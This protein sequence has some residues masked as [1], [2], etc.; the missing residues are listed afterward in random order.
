M[1]NKDFEIKSSE[2]REL[3]NTP[4]SWMAKWGTVFMLLALVAIV[5]VSYALKYPEIIT[6]DV[7]ISTANPPVPVVAKTVGVLSEIYIEEGQSVL[8]GEEI[9]LSSN[10][11][12]YSDIIEL[13]HQLKTFNP[14][15]TTTY[16]IFYDYPKEGDESMILG[17]VQNEF[18]LL[19]NY[20]R[21]YRISSQNPEKGLNEVRVRE[22]I[23]SL[24]RSIIAEKK[25]LPTIRRSIEVH[26]KLVDSK[27]NEYG[28]KEITLSEFQEFISERDIMEL[29]E[30]KIKTNISEREL[31]IANLNRQLKALKT[32][33]NY[34]SQI[35]FAKITETYKNLKN[36]V[37]NWKR[38]NLITAPASGVIS[39]YDKKA[40]QNKYYKPDEEILAILS[41]QS[42]Q[43]EG[44]VE[45]PVRH[46]GRIQEGQQ[47][48]I[49][50]HSFP[51]QEFGK[52]E[53]TVKY[54]SKVPKKG[55]HFI[56][57]ELTNHLTTTFG[58]EI[59]EEQ[60]LVGVADIITSDKSL[61]QTVFQE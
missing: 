57:V 54:K 49:K 37:E 17:E 61:F 38:K 10:D 14:G 26:R 46:I 39:F 56:G 52:I 13:E 1:A 50:L 22:R 40:D 6:A 44:T 34:G 60:E 51:F 5:G 9:A 19:I 24:K 23:K 2:I 11:A 43:L 58:K 36:A 16:D 30:M 48:F 35:S 12:I 29:E 8:K 18:D 53:G 25:K 28:R 4:P 7:T 3:L 21:D 41:N 59:P 47:V 27:Q 15:N 33:N 42:D 31:E 32:T 55:I 20:L 45:L